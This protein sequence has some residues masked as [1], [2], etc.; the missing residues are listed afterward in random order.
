MCLH[1]MQERYLLR[2]KGVQNTVV[3]F[4]D[5]RCAGFCG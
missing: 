3:Q 2:G 5:E 4:I 1:T